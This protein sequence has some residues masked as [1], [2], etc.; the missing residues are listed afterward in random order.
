MAKKIISVIVLFLL[1]LSSSSYGAVSADMSVYVR[2][3]VFDAKMDSLRSEIQVGN[4]RILSE[5]RILNTKLE[6]MDKRMNTIETHSFNRHE[7]LKTMIYWGFSILGLFIAFAIF[8]PSFGEF[9]RNLRKPSI[10]TED[11][12]RLIAEAQLNVRAQV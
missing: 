12:K 2:Q 7:D 8:G 1:V 6:E 3:D 5:I 4:E 11:V 9:L 10:T